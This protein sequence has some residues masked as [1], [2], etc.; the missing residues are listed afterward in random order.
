VGEELT[1]DT[2]DAQNCRMRTG[3]SRKLSKDDQTRS[4][5]PSGMVG[6]PELGQA[7]RRALSYTCWPAS[8]D[9]GQVCVCVHVHCL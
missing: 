2:R 8:S 5:Q 1:Q 6:K 9:P 7:R 3:C 4:S